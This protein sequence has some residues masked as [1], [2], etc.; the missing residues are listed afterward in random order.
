MK[1]KRKKEKQRNKR[2]KK[3]DT[4]KRNNFPINACLKLVF[5]FFYYSITTAQHET[6]YT[7]VLFLRLSVVC[8]RSYGRL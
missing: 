5:I 6:D 7:I 3:E 4:K 2:D 8:M 1:G